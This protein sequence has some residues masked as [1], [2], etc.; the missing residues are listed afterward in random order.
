M[1]TTASI[2]E[3]VYSLFEQLD[4]EAWDALVATLHPDAELADELTGEWLRGRDRVAG[5]LQ[6]QRGIVSGI[7]S[8]LRSLSSRWLG[9]ELGL[10]TFVLEQ[11]YDL[12]GIEHRENLTGTTI[13]AFDDDSERLLL[14]FHLGAQSAP[15]EATAE[16]GGAV[17]EPMTLGQTLRRRR[18]DAELTLRGLGERSG[19]SA[20]FLSQL[21]RGT[22]EPSISSL[23]RV[24][25]ALGIPVAEVLG[26]H[27]LAGRAVERI[28]RSGARRRV[29]VPASGLDLELLTDGAAGD[30]EV[31]IFTLSA[32][33]GGPQVSGPERGE[34]FLHV[35]EG[36]MR[37]TFDGE[38]VI[39]ER[40]DSL[41]IAPGVAYAVAADS[42]AP[43]RCLSAL[44]RSPGPGKA[45]S[46]G[47]GDE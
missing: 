26:Q 42:R 18:R 2:D 7:S 22:A 31:T 20:S 5:Y 45:S 38:A 12:D 25:E 13:F 29:D 10:A 23:K 30:L 27:A 35:L 43:L 8:R 24:A 47:M 16:S 32:P 34:R 1:R 37:V 9:P 36:R 28:V 6:A 19:L 3:A 17:G 11:R 33:A 41:T 40:G 14:L 21:E 15:R 39:L 44:V 4:A 46:G